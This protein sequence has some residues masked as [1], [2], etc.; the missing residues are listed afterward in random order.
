MLWVELDLPLDVT[1]GSLPP[2]TADLR[3]HA[4]V[5][6]QRGE[7]GRDR[8][9]ATRPFNARRRSLLSRYL[10]ASLEASGRTDD[11]CLPAPDAGRSSDSRANRRLELPNAGLAY[12]SPLPNLPPGSHLP[13]REISAWGE[14]RSRLPLRGSPGVSPG[15][16]FAL[17]TR[18]EH[19]HE[20]KILGYC[21]AVNPICWGGG[22]R[23]SIEPVQ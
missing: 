21:S 16:L 7:M 23:I 8:E 2:I 12:C 17:S 22:Q 14:C 13:E 18:S 9:G 19:Q 3:P 10:A 1:S 5:S 20:P 15:S 6:M 4:D 11:G